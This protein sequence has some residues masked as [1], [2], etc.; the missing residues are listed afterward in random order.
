MTVADIEELLVADDDGL[1]ERLT[2]IMNWHFDRAMTSVRLSFGAAASLL[3]ALL[4]ALFGN[5]THLKEWE[6]IVIGVGIV[7]SAAYG[8]YG[9]R[10]TKA[11]HADYVAA[12]RLLREMAPLTPVL[13][14][15]REI[16][17]D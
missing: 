14:V 3:A 13:R 1:A 17:N 6:G 15:F 2:Q 10:Q 7:A 16:A 4:A 5:H 9:L 12:I 8:V 11:V